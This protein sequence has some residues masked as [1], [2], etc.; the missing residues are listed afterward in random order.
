VCAGYTV[1]SHRIQHDVPGYVLNYTAYPHE[2]SD[3]PEPG[4]MNLN[5]PWYVMTYTGYVLN[6][7]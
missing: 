4:M 3:V 7:P 2:I 5:V 6:E 1:G